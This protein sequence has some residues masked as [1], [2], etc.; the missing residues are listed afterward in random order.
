MKPMFNNP[1]QLVLTKMKDTVHSNFV[2]SYTVLFE[3]SMA[4]KQR[5]GLKA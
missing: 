1:T 2:P 5:T 3:T 4:E